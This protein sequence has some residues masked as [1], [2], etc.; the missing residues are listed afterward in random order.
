MGSHPALPTV[1]VLIISRDRRALLTDALR[2][3]DKLDY[4]REKLQVVVVEDTDDPSPPAGVVYIAQPRD[5]KGRSFARNVSLQASTGEVLAFTDD[6]CVVDPWWLRELVTPLLLDAS[7]GGVAGAVLPRD[8]SLLGLCEHV[9]G[10]PGGGLPY[11]H[12]AGGQ[13]VE[14]RQ[15]NTVNCAYRRAVVLEA[16]GFHPRSVWSGEDYLLA[17]AVTKKHRCVFSPRAVVYHQARGSLGKLFERFFNFGLGEIEMLG[18]VD[19]RLSLVRHM[20]ST[21]LS[22]KYL[23]LLLILFLAKSSPL[24]ILGA[25]VAHYAY[26]V[27]SLR[28]ITGYIPRRDVLWAAPAVRFVCDL[29]LDCGRTW[30]LL[31]RLGRRGPR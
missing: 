7:L 2:S 21:S 25:A 1:S 17:Q 13:I 29:G 14:T 12:A 11:V 28:Y 3:I 27:F 31:Q 15:L 19:A 9:L 16:G 4:P 22:L 26:L 20:V 18:I 23:G 5:H 8:Q 10:Y 6:D 30:A 24:W